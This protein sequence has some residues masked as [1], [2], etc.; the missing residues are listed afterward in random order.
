MQKHNDAASAQLRRAIMSDC[1]CPE[2]IIMPSPESAT[3]KGS[4]SSQVRRL[5]GR[6]SMSERVGGPSSAADGGRNHFLVKVTS[7]RRQLRVIQFQR[8]CSVASCPAS[9]SLSNLSYP[10]GHTYGRRAVIGGPVSTSD[11]RNSSHHIFFDKTD[12]IAP[13]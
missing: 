11:P 9:S 12:Q 3:L 6:R 5:I 1:I 2:Q 7:C 13:A 8:T 10:F 4:W